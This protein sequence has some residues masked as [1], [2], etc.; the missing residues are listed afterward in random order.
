MGENNTSVYEFEPT[1]IDGEVTPLQ[2]YEGKVL[3]IVNTASECGFTPQY[4]GLQNI[5][6]KYNDQGFEVLGFPANNFGGQEPGSDEEIKQF[7]NVNY[8][9]GFP[10]FSKISVKGEDQHPLF[11][12]LTTASNPDFT[13]EI[14]WNFEKFLIGKDG[15]LVHRFRSD[16]KPESD[17][18]LKAIETSLDS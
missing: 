17:E 18:I 11:K 5:Y 9:V 8:D 2:K 14:K 10:L 12:Y 4:E 16:T 6:E 3:L 13:G 15:E 7:C 1:N